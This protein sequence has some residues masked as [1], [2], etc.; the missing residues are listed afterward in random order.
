MA[1]LIGRSEWEAVAEIGDVVEVVMPSDLD[2][3]SKHTQPHLP[4]SL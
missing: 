2:A 3:I 1:L 4:Q